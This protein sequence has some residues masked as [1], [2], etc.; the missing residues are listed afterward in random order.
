MLSQGVKQHGCGGENSGYLG[1]TFS[2]LIHKPLKQ[3][4]LSVPRYPM[5]YAGLETIDAL[6][7]FLILLMVMEFLF[8][9]D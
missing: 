2:P 9:I 6:N 4:T 5:N 8:G 1:F 7:Q 3:V